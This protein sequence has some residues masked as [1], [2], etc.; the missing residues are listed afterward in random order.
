MIYDLNGICDLTTKQQNI[1]NVFLVYTILIYVFKIF[2]MSKDCISRNE[3]YCQQF[4]SIYFYFVTFVIRLGMDAMVT[5]QMI[6]T[7]YLKCAVNKI[8]PLLVTPNRELK[9]FKKSYI[10]IADCY[11]KIRPFYD[12]VVSI[13]VVDESYL[14]FWCPRDLLGRRFTGVRVAVCA[15]TAWVCM[16]LPVSTANQRY[17]VPV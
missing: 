13:L 14:V 1:S 7:Y 11:D 9:A 5:T 12:W 10:A 15:E 8:K 17:C 4:I 2:F 3:P 16:P 6:I